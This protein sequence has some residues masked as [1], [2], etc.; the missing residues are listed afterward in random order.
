MDFAIAY[1]LA[2]W[3]C[4]TAILICRINVARSVANL[5]S[6]VGN[7]FEAWNLLREAVDLIPIA[8]PREL[9]GEDQQFITSQLSDLS[10]EA[11]STALAAGLPVLDALEILERGRGFI[12]AA[13]YGAASQLGD[14]EIKSPELYREFDRLQRQINTGSVEMQGLPFEGEGDGFTTRFRNVGGPPSSLYGGITPREHQLSQIERVIQRIRNEVPGL[15]DFLVPMSKSRIQSLAQ[16]GPV[17]ALVAGKTRADAILLFPKA[18][19]RR[20]TNLE[21]FTACWVSARGSYSVAGRRSYLSH[22]GEM[23]LSF[24]H[25]LD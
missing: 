3:E 13:V 10:N 16:E 6:N 23:V 14:L 7:V 19:R 17:V 1:Y 15:Q 22:C 21:C 2:C 18:S 4:L 11:C 8:Y 5:L 9:R 12:I 25:F 20:T 24:S